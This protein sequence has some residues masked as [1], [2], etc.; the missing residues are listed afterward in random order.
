MLGRRLLQLEATVSLVWAWCAVQWVPF[1]SLAPRL[2]APVPDAEPAPPPLSSETQAEQIRQIRTV[3][4][5]T[6]D[7]L[8]WHSSCLVRA[9]AGHAVLRRRKIPCTI[10]FG[11]NREGGTLQAHAWLRSGAQHVS[12]QNEAPQYARICGFGWSPHQSG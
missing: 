10:H 9:L 5:Q 12:G 11:V 7:R 3:L 6:A 1:S 8:P 2:G 4:R